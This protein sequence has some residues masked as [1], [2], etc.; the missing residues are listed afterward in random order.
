MHL[1]TNGQGTGEKGN[2][3][4]KSHPSGQ[5]NAYWH[6]RTWETSPLELKDCPNLNSFLWQ[7][8]GDCCAIQNQINLQENCIV[9]LI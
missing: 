3:V 5:S 8:E 9:A 1:I 2:C 4:H 6:P 7:A